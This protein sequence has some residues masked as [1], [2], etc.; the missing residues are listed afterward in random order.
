[1]PGAIRTWKTSGA[2][3]AAVLELERFAG[4]IRMD[5]RGNAVFPHFDAEGLCGYEITNKGFTGF[6]AGGSKGLWFSQAKPEDNRLVFCE[7]AIDALSHAALYPAQDTRYASIGGQVNPQQPELIRAAVAR[8]PAG[9]EIVA[10]MDA[11]TE[12]GKLSGMVRKAVELSG[13]ADLR[14]TLQESF[15]FKDWKLPFPATVLITP[16]VEISRSLPLILSATY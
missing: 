7:S 3:P 13:R 12:G 5:A 4:R 16:V 8:M 10:P 6:A 1:M 9:S 2:I 15:G 11:D 14:F